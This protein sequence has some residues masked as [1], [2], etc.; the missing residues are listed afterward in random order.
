MPETNTRKKPPRKSRDD[1]KLE[2]LRAAREVFEEVGYERATVAEIARRIG[3]VEGTVFHYVGS[4]RALVLDVME[5][6]YEQA[7]ATQRSGLQG[8][9]GTRNRLHYVIRFHVANMH[10]NAALC[11]VILR[12]SRGID[13]ELTRDIRRLN[14]A[15]TDPLKQVLVNG[16]EAGEIRPDIELPVV[17]NMVYGGIE[18][19]LWDQLSERKTI[20]VDEL[21]EQITEM[22]FHGIRLPPSQTQQDELTAL[23]ARLNHLLAKSSQSDNA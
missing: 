23:A 21:A 3:V 20:K 4:K 7:T 15:Y 12:E 18:H 1:R 13:N 16:I 10:D 17:R 9:R 11:G 5:Q 6:F 8:I 2:I 19:A 22:V 14:R